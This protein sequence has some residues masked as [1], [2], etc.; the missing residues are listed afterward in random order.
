MLSE[1]IKL[2]KEIE[3][4]WY[5][6][7]PK[8]EALAKAMFDV[9]GKKSNDNVLILEGV[10]FKEFVR[11]FRSAFLKIIQDNIKKDELD[12]KTAELE[13]EDVEEEQNEDDKEPEDEKGK[14]KKPTKKQLLREEIKKHIK[15]DIYFRVAKSDKGIQD[16]SIRLNPGMEH[17]GNGW[18]REIG[19]YNDIY[20]IL[21]LITDNNP[22]N[23][24]AL[25]DL[26][27]KFASKAFKFTKADL[28]KVNPKFS[29][30]E[31]NN[32]LIDY[33]LTYLLR[34]ALL[35]LFYE[36]AR[37]LVLNEGD[38]EYSI[39]ESG[40]L[41]VTSMIIVLKL[42]KEGKLNDLK[43]AFSP[44]SEYILCTKQSVSKIS[45]KVV[46][47]LTNNVARFGFEKL[48]QKYPGQEKFD[49][50]HIAGSSMYTNSE[51]AEGS[52]EYKPNNNNG[53]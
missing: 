3:E 8:D 2:V 48:Q 22:A 35:Y 27:L 44:D 4:E 12:K 50:Q 42:M 15:N 16:M 11:S 10:S 13:A 5:K 21:C 33:Y 51:E 24:Q 18:I 28:V 45:K 52:E 20:P 53:P 41:F 46:V 38:T 43:D 19:E 36:P 40:N 49:P 32:T 1:F 14:K 25:A 9:L 7:D 6:R 31:F 47:D 37:R 39:K 30:K 23:N 17:L 29:N 26:F 34:T